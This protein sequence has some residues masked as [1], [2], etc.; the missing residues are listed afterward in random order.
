MTSIFSGE[1]QNHW[2]TFLFSSGVIIYLYQ[3]LPFSCSTD[4]YFIDYYTDIH[5]K[6]LKIYLSKTIF[7]NK[8]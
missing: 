3:S 1:K 8:W 7:V 2:E 6:F 5:S 4:I